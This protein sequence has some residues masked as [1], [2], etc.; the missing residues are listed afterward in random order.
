MLVLCVSAHSAL[1]HVHHQYVVDIDDALLQLTP[2]RPRRPGSSRPPSGQYGSPADTR[3]I[4]SIESTSN[5]SLNRLSQDLSD[6]SVPPPLPVKHSTSIVSTDS[7]RLS[8][9]PDTISTHTITPVDVP[10]VLPEVTQDGAAPPL[11]PQK[12][13]HPP[14]IGVDTA[15]P[16]L[17]EKHVHTPPSKPEIS[18]PLLPDKKPPRL[19]PKVTSGSAQVRGCN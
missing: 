12:H 3:S 2:T 8:L 7:Q 9:A 14:A 19:R 6:S 4:S 15:Q 13:V 16:L 11:L 10:V 5:T 1:V 18:Q 17:P